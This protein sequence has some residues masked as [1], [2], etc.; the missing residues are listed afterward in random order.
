[1][2]GW[3]T[4]IGIAWGGSGVADTAFWPTGTTLSYRVKVGTRGMATGEF[5]SLKDTWDYAVTFALGCEAA[6]PSKRMQSMNCRL[7][8][9]M[10]SE[11]QGGR[12]TVV[13]I[14]STLRFELRWTA[15]RR[16]VL[17]ETVGGT[18]E[19]DREH[20]VLLGIHALEMEIPDSP[21]ALGTSW[22][23]GGGNQLMK[24]V[25]NPGAFEVSHSVTANADGVV[26]ITS[27]GHSYVV[28]SGTFDPM[29]D[30]VEYEGS[31]VT[32]YE[33]E[34]SLILDRSFTVQ[35]TR[36]AAGIRAPA[37]MHVEVV[38]E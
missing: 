3:L 34:R 5:G 37:S 22:R 36:V 23:Q 35:P 17:I 2:I 31:G 4:F 26:E 25:E 28:P 21:L 33:L 29:G 12:E 1:M 15:S 24:L 8:D 9:D 10:L 13:P 32:R 38:L 18:I 6:A 11:Q 7:G 30:R 27:S 20:W 16:L 14:P 19:P